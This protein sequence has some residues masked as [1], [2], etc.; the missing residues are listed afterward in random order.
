MTERFFRNEVTYNM[1]V[2]IEQYMAVAISAPLGDPDAM[3]QMS[4]IYKAIKV[5]EE[6]VPESRSILMETRS[7]CDKLNL[8][9]F[10]SGGE[11]DNGDG[12]SNL[13]VY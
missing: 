13:S 12:R 10:S 11:K 3:K 8:V 4:D 1:A 7:H 6:Y 2:L 5:L 9:Y